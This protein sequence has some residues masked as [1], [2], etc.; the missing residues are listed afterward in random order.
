MNHSIIYKNQEIK[1]SIRANK[2]AKRIILRIS[3]EGDVA[4]TIPNKRHERDA[5]QLIQ[6][7]AAWISAHLNKLDRETE[8]RPKVIDEIRFLG[9]IYPVEVLPGSKRAKLNFKTNKFELKIGDHTYDDVRIELK[10][11]YTKKARDVIPNLIENF[12]YSDRVKRI[13]IKGQKTCWGS[14]SSKNN[15]N[16]N[17][18]LMM[19]PMAVVNYVVCHELTHLDHMDH[20]ARFWNA[21]RQKCPDYNQHKGWL[22]Q[23]GRLLKF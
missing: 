16:F 11:W 13:A 7:K 10:K 9:N 3:N 22:K 21:V 2:Q 6:K 15:L 5:I 17:W 18:K 19:A 23:H 4:V 1:F 14:C 20:S 12:G 8:S